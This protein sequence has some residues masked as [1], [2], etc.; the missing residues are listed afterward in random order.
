MDSQAGSRPPASIASDGDVDGTLVSR[1]NPPDRSRTS[2]ARDRSIANRKDRGDA[3][4]FEADV[5]MSHG[6]HAAVKPVQVT[7][8][9]PSLNRVAMKARVAQLMPADDTVLPSRDPGDHLVESGTLFP[10]TGNKAP[11]PDLR[12]RLRALAGR[13][14]SLHRRCLALSRALRLAPSL[15]VFVPCRAAEWRPL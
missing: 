5:R 11:T 15:Q 8:T 9:Q 6:I 7:S 10:H 14:P 4:A 13:R 3:A 1:K 12:P 2:M